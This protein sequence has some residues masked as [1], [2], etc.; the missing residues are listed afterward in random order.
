MVVCAERERTHRNCGF[1]AYDEALGELSGTI[2]PLGGLGGHRGFG[3][4]RA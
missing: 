1:K 4:V 3:R 2:D